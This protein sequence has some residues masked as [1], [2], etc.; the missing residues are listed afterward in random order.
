[1][2]QEELFLPAPGAYTGVHPLLKHQRFVLAL[3]LDTLVS[4]TGLG[5]HWEEG[6]LYSSFYP[7]HPAQDLASKVRSINVWWRKTL[8]NYKGKNECAKKCILWWAISLFLNK[9]YNW[10]RV[11]R[12]NSFIHLCIHSKQSGQML[13]RIKKCVGQAKGYN[14]SK[15]MSLKCR[16][17]FSLGNHL[18]HCCSE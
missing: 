8:Q 6:V 7:T 12:G 13:L 15:G 17:Q 18:K 5:A 10:L 2:L 11:C 16:F 1:M 4:C 9:N 14:G 3:L